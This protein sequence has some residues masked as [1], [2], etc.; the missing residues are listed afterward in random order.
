MLRHTSGLAGA[1][2][3]DMQVLWFDAVG[4][5]LAGLTSGRLIGAVMRVF[6]TGTVGLR[7]PDPLEDPQ[8]DVALLSDPRDGVRLRE[9]VHRIRAIL[10]HPDV[11]AIATSTATVGAE[12]DDLD[13]DDAVDEWLG[14]TV[15][16]CV[17]A[18]GTCR[19]RAPGDPAAVVDPGCRVRDY[20]ALRVCDAS[21]MPS[22][23]RAN[24]HLSAI[25]VAEVLLTRIAATA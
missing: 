19:M 9:C 20:R 14:A 6:S 3:A 1:G 15:N 16:D 2:S 10:R 21:V 17:H 24:T 4:P 23:P 12:L 22:A 11:E 5:D 25:A 7:T 8:V 13:S 18:V